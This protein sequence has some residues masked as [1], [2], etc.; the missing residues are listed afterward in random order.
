MEYPTLE[1]VK[2]ASK[3]ELAKWYRFLP[4]PGSK[5]ILKSYEVFDSKLK[6]EQLVMNTIV[7]RFT[8]MGGFDPQLSKQVGWG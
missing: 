8:E 7:E 4:S 2:T 6:E 5:H 3:Y 1:V